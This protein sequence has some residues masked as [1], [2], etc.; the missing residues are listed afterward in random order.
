MEK[1][2]MLQRGWEG[3]CEKKNFTNIGIA[4]LECGYYFLKI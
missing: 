1:Q 2:L 3:C 4:C